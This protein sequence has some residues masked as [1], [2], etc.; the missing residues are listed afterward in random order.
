[1]GSGSLTALTLPTLGSIGWTYQLYVFPS[2]S[3]SK[4][5]RRTTN[6]GVQVR[7]TSDAGGNLIGRW[8]YAT[9]LASNTAGQL[10]N[11]VTDPLGNQ[12]VRYFS[13]STTNG[14]GPGPNVFDYGRPYTPNT[15]YGNLF[16]SE[17][18]FDSGGTL[19]RESDHAI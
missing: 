11:T 8:T 12:H 13:V 5:P 15:S 10:V 7:T 16:L 3:S 6:P 14:Y 4:P 18:V 17:Q 1:M 2:A 19:R 9:Y